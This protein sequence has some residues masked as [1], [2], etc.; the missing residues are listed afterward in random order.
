M[1]GREQ[2]DAE[3]FAIFQCFN[4]YALFSKLASNIKNWIAKTIERS[5]YNAT[6]DQVKHNNIPA[7]WINE[8]FVCQYSSIG[9]TVKINLDINSSINSNKPDIIRC[10]VAKKCYNAVMF[11]IFQHYA[12]LNKKIADII[13]S[14]IGAINP[15]NIGYLLSKQLNPHINEPY[16]HQLE[17]RSEQTTKIKYSKMYTCTC[18]KKKTKCYER[19]TRGL[20]EGATVFLE[21][22]CGR[23]WKI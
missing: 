15:K 7:Y 19:Q 20:D 13:I 12:N 2:R 5:I 22:E 1:D 11:M 18:G 8:I 14:H 4:E 9:F 23:I 21:C 17:I 16:Y 3:K 6:I 10:Y